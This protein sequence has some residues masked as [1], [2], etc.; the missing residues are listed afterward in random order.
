MPSTPSPSLLIEIQQGGENL[1][2]WGDGRLN[3][4]LKMLEAQLQGLTEHTLTGNISLTYTNYTLTNGSDFVQK[5]AAAS[6]GAYQI[7]LGARERTHLILNASSYT[8]TIACA[9]AGA[10]VTVLAGQVCMVYCDGTNVVKTFD[11]ADVTYVLATFLQ[12]AG[13]TMTG[14]LI[15][16]GP[17]STDMMAGN[18]KYIDDTA[19]SMALGSFPGLTGNALK[20]LRVN[21]AADNVE[22]AA[23]TTLAEYGITDAEPL[24]TYLVTSGNVS[25]AVVNTHYGVDSASAA[26]TITL[27]A[28]ASGRIIVSDKDGNAALNNITIARNSNTIAGFGSDYVINTNRGWVELIGAS[29]DWR[30]A[31]GR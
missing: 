3:T 8:Q 2:S 21:A 16:A 31:R 4:A 29:S 27:P 12:L 17:P 13:G 11:G 23:S 22:W 15:L 6:N 1:N 30:I 7:T 9:G 25:P 14:P 24:I 18:K 26:R 19:F 10:S 20:R 28:V 5:I